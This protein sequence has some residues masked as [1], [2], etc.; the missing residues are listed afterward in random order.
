MAILSPAAKFLVKT[1]IYDEKKFIDEENYYTQR[2]SNVSMLSSKMVY[3]TGMQERSLPLATRLLGAPYFDVSG[4]KKGEGENP[5]SLNSTTKTVETKEFTYPVMTQVKKGSEVGKNSITGTPG[6]GFQPFEVLYKTNGLHKNFF[7]RSP[8]GTMLY[9]TKDPVPEGNQFRYTLQLGSGAPTQ[10]VDPLEFTEGTVWINMF[11]AIAESETRNIDIARAITPSYFKNQLTK[12]RIGMS[13]GGDAANFKT[14][15]LTFVDK[16]PEGEISV[17][18]KGNPRVMW[19]DQYMYNFEVDS[20]EY[21]ESL[22]W[23]QEYNRQVNGKIPLID[24][25]TGKPIGVG[26]GILQQILNK[27]SYTSFSYEMLNDII[28]RAY[29]GI[30]GTPKTKTLYTGTL[31]FRK[32]DAAMKKAGFK[33]LTDWGFVSNLFVTGTDRNLMLGGYFD[34]FYHIDGWIIKVKKVDIFDNGLISNSPI[35]EESGLPYESARMVLLDDAEM[36]GESNLQLLMGKGYEP[37]K[38]AIKRGMNDV[39]LS[40]K[41]FSDKNTLDNSSIANV[42]DDMDKS[43][44][45]RM[46]NLGVQLMRGNTSID[47]Q[48]NPAIW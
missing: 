24:G 47:F 33:L 8:K 26:A 31:G 48:Y 40:M 7:I 1:G 25:F 10:F 17:D 21:I 39:P 29:Y 28:G 13:W 27:V 23:Y 5:F 16:T 19:M 12:A 3:M 32:F 20:M 45:M 44:Y 38:H 37:Y 2:N 43:T 14:K 35:D 46:Y 11:P 30:K 34:G 9:V 41:M 15:V 6:L 36:D 4:M 42:S 18:E 22:L